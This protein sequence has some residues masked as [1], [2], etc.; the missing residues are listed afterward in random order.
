ME[1]SSFGHMAI[2]ISFFTFLPDR[3]LK[4]I[5]LSIEWSSGNNMQSRKDRVVGLN[6]AKTGLKEVLWT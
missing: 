3:F 6:K 5:G 2:S 1:K 4:S